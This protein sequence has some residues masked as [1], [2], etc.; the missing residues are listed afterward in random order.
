ML[1]MSCQSF[2]HLSIH[3][4]FYLIHKFFVNSFFMLKASEEFDLLLK[5]YFIP[6]YLARY[7]I[8]VTRALFNSHTSSELMNSVEFR[9]GM[10]KILATAARASFQS[11]FLF[12][13]TYTIH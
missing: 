9:A 11:K 3:I 10:P 1:E 6:K 13:A 2:A 7:G 12:R 8:F 5:K 4:F